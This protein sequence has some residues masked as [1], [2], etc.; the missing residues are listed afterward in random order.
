MVELYGQW[1]DG[2]GQ[3]PDDALFD[4]QFACKM[5]DYELCKHLPAVG[6]KG[7]A[8][9]N[10]GLPLVSNILTWSEDG[11][12]QYRTGKCMS[13]PHLFA[14][15]GR[16]FSA[17]ELYEYYNICRPVACKK[18]HSSWQARFRQTVAVQRKAGTRRWGHGR[19]NG[20]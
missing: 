2:H 4:P 10:N 8:V 18:A 15:C 9:R 14:K 12:W 20:H 19:H 17:A 7:N 11:T 3:V 6:G 1:E 13:L 5:E 16:F